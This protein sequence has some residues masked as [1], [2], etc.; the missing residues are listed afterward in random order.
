MLNVSIIIPSKNAANLVASILAVRSLDNSFPLSSFIVVD[1]GLNRRDVGLHLRYVTGRTPF[2]FA[3]NI[4]MGIAAA[5][6]HD[7]ILMNDDAVL[8][9][10]HGLWKMALRSRLTPTIG[11]CSAAIQGDICNPQ[12][13]PAGAGNDLRIVR[14]DIAFVCVYIP[15]R[16]IESVGVLDERFD[17]YGFEDFDYCRRVR[18]YGLDVGVFDG[19]VMEHESLPSTFRTRDDV[20][21]MLTRARQ[22][23]RDKWNG[24]GADK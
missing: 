14:D 15:R 3:R 8:Q 24:V 20:G 19:C 7:V 5:G 23:Y 11:I 4:N 9:T 18:K 13:H 1:D 22:L 10:R 16:V 2:I 17:G 12:Q 6:R 21:E